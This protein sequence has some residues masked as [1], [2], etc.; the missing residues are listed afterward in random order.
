MLI[1]GY[2]EQ[3]DPGLPHISKHSP[4]ISYCFLPLKRNGD[5]YD[6]CCGII[7]ATQLQFSVLSMSDTAGICVYCVYVIIHHN[8]TVIITPR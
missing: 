7:I 3:W 6:Y 8:P 2:K 5:V 4:E 1:A